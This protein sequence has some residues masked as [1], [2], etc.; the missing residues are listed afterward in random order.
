MALL[1]NKQIGGVG[2]Q[3]YAVVTKFWHTKFERFSVPVGTEP[4]I[5]PETQE[6]MVDPKGHPIM[7]IVYDEVPVVYT[8]VEY[9]K[10]RDTA[11]QLRV[12]TVQDIIT[13]KG[14]DPNLAGSTIQQ[15]YTLLKDQDPI[16]AEG[17]DIL[18]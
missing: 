9:F 1:V 14:F 16:F 15:L 11:H 3:M 8:Q 13:L 18:E 10:D 17:I 12:S 2:V 4:A 6:P 7:T 5:N